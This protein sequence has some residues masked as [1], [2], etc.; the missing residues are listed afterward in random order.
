MATPCGIFQKAPRGCAVAWTFPRRVFENAK[1]A[2]FAPTS[3]AFIAARLLGF[4]TAMRMFAEIM[5]I[6][7]RARPS[8]IGVDSRDV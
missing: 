2:M 3:R 5:R 7:C 4:A 6:A 8:L 1:P